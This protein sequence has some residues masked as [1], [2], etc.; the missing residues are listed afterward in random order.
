MCICVD[1]VNDS[2]REKNTRLALSFG[3]SL[4]GFVAPMIK[5]E[6]ISNLRDGGKPACV[7]AQ[8][9]PFCGVRY[10]QEKETST[11]ETV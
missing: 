8:Y 2:L 1:A 10:G 11:K 5:T 7:V 6:R 9:C 3:A 4:L